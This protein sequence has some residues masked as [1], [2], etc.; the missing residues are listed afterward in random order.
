MRTVNKIAI[1]TANFGQKYGLFP[2]KNFFSLSEIKK[3][4]RKS[5]KN[6]ITTLDTAYHYIN[7]EKK[8]GKL[9][10]ISYLQWV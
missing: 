3:I 8:L 4:L 5:K 2:K 1:G 9:D 6:N 7:A 10:L